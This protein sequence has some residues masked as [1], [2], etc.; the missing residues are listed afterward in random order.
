MKPKGA[1]QGWSIYKSDTNRMDVFQ[2]HCWCVSGSKVHLSC[3]WY[4]EWL[5]TAG[6]VPQNGAGGWANGWADGWAS[7][8][9]S[10]NWFTMLT[11]VTI[12]ICVTILTRVT[13]L[14]FRLSINVPLMPVTSWL[15]A[16]CAKSTLCIMV[17]RT[18]MALQHLSTRSSWSIVQLFWGLAGGN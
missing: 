13:I 7:I 1:T 3:V 11:H 8:L 2:L 17:N 16:L 6:S 15:L 18:C 4:E 10:Q 12:L 5:Y 14:V 9:L